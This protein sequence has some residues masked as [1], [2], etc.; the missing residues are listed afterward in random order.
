MMKFLIASFVLTLAS[1][2]AFAETSSLAEQAEKL[3]QACEAAVRPLD[4]GSSMPSQGHAMG[5][6]GEGDMGAMASMSGW[7]QL[8]M[9]AAT[10]EDPDL[11]FN[12]GMIAHHMGAI[13]MAEEEL[14]SGKDEASRAMAETIIKVQRK[15]IEDMTKRVES[16]KK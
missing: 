6:G 13:A 11:S 12:C 15:E 9:R 7:E 2:Q 16:L 10:I 3:P 8:M 5:H 14:R 1:G 4:A